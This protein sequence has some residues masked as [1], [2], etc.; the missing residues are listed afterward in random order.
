MHVIVCVFLYNHVS[1]VN[2]LRLKLLVR[3]EMFSVDY[4]I[5]T[6]RNTINIA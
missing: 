3:V 4:F 2:G 6:A 1:I 5:N